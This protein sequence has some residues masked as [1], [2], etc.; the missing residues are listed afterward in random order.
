MKVI[1]DRVFDLKQQFC[2]PQPKSPCK[3]S[4]LAQVEAQALHLLATVV[5]QVDIKDIQ[6]GRRIAKKMKHQMMAR[7]EALFKSMDDMCP[8]KED[9]VADPS[10]LMEFK[11]NGEVEPV[12][13]E[14]KNG[15][16]KCA[17]WCW[18]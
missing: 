9:T 15:S 14:V 18:V 1:E 6:S 3:T 11:E 12:V 2:E 8:Q 4:E 5:E 7:F 10:H 13:L 16:V 17:S